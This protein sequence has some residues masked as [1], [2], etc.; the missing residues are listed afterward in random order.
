M[1][2]T[3]SLDLRFPGTVKVTLRSAMV[4]VHLYGSAACSWASW[5]RAAASSAGVVSVAGVADVSK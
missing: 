5:A 4:C 1:A 2:M 3:R